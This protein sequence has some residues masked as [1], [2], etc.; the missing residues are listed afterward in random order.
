MF[1]G[2]TIR[3]G[4][5]ISQG[6]KLFKVAVQG[7]N[8]LLSCGGKKI[9]LGVVLK[10]AHGGPLES[11]GVPILSPVGKNRDKIPSPIP[12]GPTTITTLINK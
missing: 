2:K 10:G 5:G 3:G 12:T 11:S 1:A 6:L 9:T 4:H 7:P 8:T